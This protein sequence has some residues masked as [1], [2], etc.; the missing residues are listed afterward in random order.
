MR[1]TVK[2]VAVALLSAFILGSGASQLQAQEVVQV[3]IGGPG[4]GPR[5]L[6]ESFFRALGSGDLALLK[7]GGAIS[8]TIQGDQFT[9]QLTSGQT[10]T[11]TR[12][13]IGS[14]LFGETDQLVLTDGSTLSGSVAGDSFSIS[15]QGNTLTIPADDIQLTIF[16]LDLPTPDAAGQHVQGRP[17]LG[18][19]RVLHGLQAQNIFGLLAQTLSTYDM[20]MFADG[21]VWSGG[22]LNES[23][24]FNTALF[25]ALTVKA[26][27]LNGIELASEEGQ[28]DFISLKTGDRLSGTLD[29]ASLV[30][31]QPIGLVDE[32]GAQVTLT[33]ERGQVSRVS[34]RQPASAFGGGQGPGFGG[35]PGK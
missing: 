19:F 21:Q 30:Q 9:V 23:F 26:A 25:G 24:V 1:Y 35:G 34:F 16:K 5:G 27:D 32:S 31:F 17:N 14:I 33:L 22:V 11:L 2:A 7:G 8:G 13:Q 6:L 12:S 20:A 4:T 29:D 18:L 10:Q 28:S 3:Q 15:S